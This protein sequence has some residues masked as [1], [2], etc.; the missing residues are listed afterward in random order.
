[1]SVRAISSCP[2]MRFALSSTV[3]HVAHIRPTPALTGSFKR[4]VTLF[5]VARA[6]GRSAYFVTR[7]SQSDL[8][9]GCKGAPVPPGQKLPILG[10]EEIMSKKAHGTSEAPVQPNL[11]YG[12]DVD[13]ADRICRY[14]FILTL[15]LF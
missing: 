1:M 10:G 5:G 9:D 13:T 11:R 15:T 8:S 6:A 7:A 3:R 2:T 4:Q 14:T 12:C